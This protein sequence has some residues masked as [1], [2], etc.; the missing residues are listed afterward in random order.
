M[1][2]RTSLLG[3]M[4][5]LDCM[6]S[7]RRTSTRLASLT[8]ISTVPESLLTATSEA[9]TLRPV[10]GAVVGALGA[11]VGAAGADESLAA[12]GASLEESLAESLEESLESFG[13]T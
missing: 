1:V 7:M 13:A 2:P 4:F 12:F 10:E 11:V 3:R 5:V 8:W 9:V 6:L